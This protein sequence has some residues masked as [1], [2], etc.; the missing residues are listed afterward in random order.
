MNSAER[1]AE[2]SR[3]EHEARQYERQAAYGFE[4]SRSYEKH[5]K[6]EARRLRGDGPEHCPQCDCANPAGYER[7]M[8]CGTCPTCPHGLGFHCRTCWPAG[9]A[10]GA[11][12]AAS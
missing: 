6:D 9:R 1:L 7:C 4:A 2:I 5:H 10:S 8:A 12:R 11:R 3:H